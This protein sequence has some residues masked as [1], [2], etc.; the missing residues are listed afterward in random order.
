MIP[1]VEIPVED[2]YWLELLKEVFGDQGIKYQVE[3]KS[4]NHG[5]LHGTNAMRIDYYRVFVPHAVFLR[6]Q[7]LWQDI[8]NSKLI[9]P[10]EPV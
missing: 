2:F 3:A 6:A 8:L 9:D 1:L 10:K 5:S 7:K 4:S